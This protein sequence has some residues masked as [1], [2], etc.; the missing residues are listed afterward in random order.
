METPYENSQMKQNN[1]L[2]IEKLKKLF[3]YYCQYGEKLNTLILRTNKFIKLATECNIL[4]KRLTT[5][6]L[7]IIY[8]SENNRNQMNFKDFLNSLVKI[9]DFKFNTQKNSYMPKINKTK[10]LNML[11]EKFILPRYDQLYPV[12][13]LILNTNEMSRNNDS[14]QRNTNNSSF[15]NFGSNGFINKSIINVPNIEENVLEKSIEEIFIQVAPILFDIY[16][17]YFPHEIS[18]S[19]NMNFLKHESYKNYYI[20]LKEF[21]LYPS[22]ISKPVAFHIY[23]SEEDDETVINK[24]DYYLKLIQNIDLQNIF[25]Y[26]S[27]NENILGRNFNFFKFLR[28]LLKIS[29]MGY[30][31]ID[32]FSYNSIATSRN[33]SPMNT[34]YDNNSI[35][36]SQKLILTL[37]RMEFSEGFKNL[38][39]KTNK[40]HSMKNTSMITKTLIE[41]VK[42]STASTNVINSFAL[43][44]LSKD[45]FSASNLLGRISI[46]DKSSNLIYHKNYNDICR[47]TGFIS[48]N[49]GNELVHLFKAFCS[50]GDPLNT[51]YMRSQ[52]FLKL[53]NE[54]KL[55]ISRNSNILYNSN[56]TSPNTSRIAYS[57]NSSFKNLKIK[58]PIERGLNN[59]DIDTI[60]IKLS[61]LACD[62]LN[63]SC[64]QAIT[65]TTTQNLNNVYVSTTNIHGSADTSLNF[66]LFNQSKSINTGRGI[67]SGAKIDYNTFLIGIEVIARSIYPSNDPTESIDLIVKQHLLKYLSHYLIKIKSSEDKIELLKEKQSNRELIYVLGLV[68]KSFSYV[69][70]YYANNK[71]LMNFEQF[72]K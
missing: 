41:K 33:N 37:E 65:C 26:N 68:H 7:E 21:D 70:K 10:C 20:F 17:V 2:M 45:N 35:P 56:T 66:S 23:Q 54:A 22:L 59:N 19:E 38:E 49:Y 34:H 61:N 52:N 15:N 18:L 36:T 8:K 50:F 27:K 62:S 57:R 9:G 28:T 39:K 47:Y 40:T 60:F 16:K 42:S 30:E 29:E 3:E 32:K 55:I 69:Y 25:K 46:D 48:Q 43:D 72:M 63:F 11:I 5:I 71:G 1:A 14:L 58:E 13:M 67:S 44:Y 24:R 53:L 4:D 64:E 6:R 31:K 12:K 51:K